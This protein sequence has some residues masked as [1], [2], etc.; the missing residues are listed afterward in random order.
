MKKNHDKVVRNKQKK[1]HWFF[2]EII[3]LKFLRIKTVEE[4]LDKINISKKLKNLEKL[5]N[6]YIFNIYQYG[7][8]WFLYL[9]EICN[10]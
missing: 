5:D 4:K 1:M 2:E 6:F 10:L 3:I 8:L 7:D 9:F